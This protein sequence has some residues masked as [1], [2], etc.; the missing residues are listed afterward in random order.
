MSYFNE[1]N[2]VQYEGTQWTNPFSF[3]H[4]N[5]KEKL[6][7]KTLEE[8]L[9]FSMAYGTHLQPMDRIPLVLEIW[10]VHGIICRAWI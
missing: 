7:D 4:Y 1:V 9:R 5:P 8:H 3:K 2:G 10:S 6:G